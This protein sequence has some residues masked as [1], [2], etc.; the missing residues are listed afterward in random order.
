MSTLK[1]V[2]DAWDIVRK[3]RGPMEM[4]RALAPSDWLE[5]LVLNEMVGSDGVANVQDTE[6]GLASAESLRR[7]CNT[8][9]AEFID[10]GSIDYRALASSETFAELEQ[11][12]RALVHVDPNELD[13]DDA[14]NAFWINIYNV[15]AIH[16]VVALG[17]EHSVME[18]PSF[19]RRVS[20]QI[21]GYPMSLDQIEHGVLRLNALHPSSGRGTLPD[22]DPRLAFCPSEL[23][24]R[25]HMAL[26]CTA[27]SCPPVAF[28]QA[29]KLSTQLDMASANF[30]S[31]SVTVNSKKEVVKLSS[32]FKFYTDDFGG[33]EGLKTFLLT[34]ADRKQA[35]ILAKAF[36]LK[37]TWEWSRYDWSLNTLMA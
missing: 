22:G 25:I 31:G 34:H 11:V 10:A 37:W 4:V 1:K 5:P 32:L 16:G 20:Y 6:D 35:Q 29:E 17:L 26:V 8:L 13:G 30:V 21:G 12:S 36:K 7:L 24:P 2:R 33:V 19:F 28:Y 23:D 9:K 27:R 15:L 3:I 14:R 18:T